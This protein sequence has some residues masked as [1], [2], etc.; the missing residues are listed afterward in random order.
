MTFRKAHDTL[1]EVQVPAAAYYD[2]QT[3][4]AVE[5]FPLSG[6]RASAA[7]VT[8]TVLVKKSAAEANMRLGRLPRRIGRAIVQAADEILE[9]RLRDQFVV[10]V[11]QAGAGTSHNMNANE[12]IANRA[13]ELLT[14]SRGNTSLVD[15]NDH[16]N[17]GQSTNDVFPTSTRLALLLV[18]PALLGSGRKLARS[19]ERKAREFRRVLKTGRT[20]L[21]DAVPITLGQ[22]FSG[23]AACIEAGCEG[24]AR[25][26]EG[27][28]ELNLGAT[29]VG[30]GS[31]RGWITWRSPS[32]A[33]AHTR[34]STCAPPRTAS[35]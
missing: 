28:K 18:T 14:G 22:E 32:G 34:T 25:A 27:L 16:V 26:S 23:Y 21:Q 12:V 5:N 9:G 33:C 10:D 31:T 11:Y 19:L 15:P 35:A 1:G 17:M 29:A 20:H 13:A 6:F 8:A 7:L 3:Q 24:V 2:A 30:T 4:R